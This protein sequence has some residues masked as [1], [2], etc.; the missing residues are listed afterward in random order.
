MLPSGDIYHSARLAAG[1]AFAQ[2]PVHPRVVERILAHVTLS[3][4]HIERA[5]DVGCGAGLSTAALTRFAGVVVGMEPAAPML[6]HRRAVAPA[7]AFVVG[8]AEHLPF[9]AGSFDLVTA[10]GALN[11]AD[12]E[13]SLAEIARVLAPR[14][15]L[16]IYD[17]SGGR[18]CREAVP[19][20]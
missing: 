9:T 4:R 19:L 6:V 13:R 11:Y 1:Y 3:D 8:Q 16:A 10:A 5:L 2:P 17:F 15:V 18:R 12:R 14:G 20:D 7:A